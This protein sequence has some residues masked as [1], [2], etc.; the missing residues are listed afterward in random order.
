MSDDASVYVVELLVVDVSLVSF[1]YV[2]LAGASHFEKIYL[3]L[4]HAS[5]S[6]MRHVQVEVFQ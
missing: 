5:V 4:S 2:V 3:L 6:V 1:L